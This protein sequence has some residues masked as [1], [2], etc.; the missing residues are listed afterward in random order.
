MSEITCIVGCQIRKVPAEYAKQC[1]T[2]C[3]L[4]EDCPQLGQIPLDVPLAAFDY[5][6]DYC[7]RVCEEESLLESVILADFAKK[8]IFELFELNNAASFLNNGPFLKL[9]AKGIAAQI[10]GKSTEEIR[11]MLKI[12]EK[13]TDETHK[14]VEKKYFTKPATK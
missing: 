12:R 9:C 7:K 10:K 14:L 1:Q 4:I 3:D 2:I 13:F 6:M 11:E 5:I 8:T